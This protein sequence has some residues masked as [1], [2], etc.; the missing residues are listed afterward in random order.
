M[1]QPPFLRGSVIVAGLVTTA[2]TLAACGG[3][4][5]EPVRTQGAPASTSGL[6]I[7]PSQAAPEVPLSS[8]PPPTQAVTVLPNVT[9][10]RLSEGE[11]LLRANGFLAVRA[12][13]ASGEG[14]TILEKN[15][16]VITRQDPAAGAEASAELTVTLTVRRP[17]DQEPPPVVRKGVV[18]RVVCHD[19]QDAQDALRDAGFYLLLPRDGLG[20]GRIPLVDRNWIVVGQSAPAGSTPEPT[21]KIELTV[22]KFGEPTGNSKCPS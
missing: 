22:V 7:T 15:N 6:P 5:S 20:Q 17:T 9:G 3:N 14:R 2:M 18:P 1:H 10:K 8:A 16:W 13:D 19:L 21:E 4:D 12:V 11:E